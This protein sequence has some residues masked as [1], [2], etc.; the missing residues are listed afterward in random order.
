MKD[1]F[2][3]FFVGILWRITRLK[4]LERILIKDSQND[5]EENQMMIANIMLTKGRK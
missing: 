5:Q 1:G 3:T 4:F 2:K